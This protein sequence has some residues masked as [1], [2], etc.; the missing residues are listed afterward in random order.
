MKYVDWIEFEH[1]GVTQL[2]RKGCIVGLEF[3][4]DEKSR[5]G[6][7]VNVHFSHPVVRFGQEPQAFYQRVFRP[8]QKAEFEKYVENLK[9][10]LRMELSKF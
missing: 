2:V 6:H 5:T 1:G 8:D 9:K 7:V 3:W 10:E 4:S